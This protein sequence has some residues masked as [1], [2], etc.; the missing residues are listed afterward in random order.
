MYFNNPHSKLEKHKKLF[1]NI[2]FFL[3]IYQVI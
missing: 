3:N 1:I 2:M